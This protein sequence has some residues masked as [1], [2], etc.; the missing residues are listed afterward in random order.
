M[1]VSVAPVRLREQ[2][3]VKNI[4]AQSWQPVCWLALVNNI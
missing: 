2:Q 1:G 4:Y 3:A